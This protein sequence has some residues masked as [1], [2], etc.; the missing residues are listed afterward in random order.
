MKASSPFLF[1]IIR[2]VVLY[3]VLSIIYNLYLNQSLSLDPITNLVAEIVQKSLPFFGTQ[4]TLS[5]TEM[6]SASFVYL[7]SD[8]PFVKIIE[9]CNSI[10]IIIL[11]IAFTFSFYSGFSR[12]FIFALL[13]S[14][15]I[16][17]LNILRIDLFIIGLQ[18]YPEYRSLLHDILFPI[19]IYGFVLLLWLVWIFKISRKKQAHEK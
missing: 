16:F 12:T 5:F 9:G 14:I 7:T 10:S 2:F 17:A 13:G 11:F 15:S 8:I 1:F 18:H 4:A 6:Q 3:S 19:S